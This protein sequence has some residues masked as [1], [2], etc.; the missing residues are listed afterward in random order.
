MALG[1]GVWTTQSKELPGSYLNFV[2]ASRANTAL[3]A[4][5]V[6]AFPIALD[7][8]AEQTVI[9]VTAESFRKDAK[10]IFGYAQSHASLKGLRDLFRNIRK[11]YFFRLNQGGMKA[12]N[13]YACARHPGSRGND[14][15]IVIQNGEDST[16]EL[17][18]YDVLTYLDNEQVDE[19]RG[20]TSPAALASN[21]YVEFKRD[22]VLELT[23]GAP[24]VGGVTGAVKN[25]AYQTCIDRL[26][27]YAFNTLG[28]LS[29]DETVKGLFAA[30]VKRLRDELGVKCQCV[31]FR[32][33]RADYE[34]V[35]SVENGLR[36]AKDDP[37]AVFWMTGASAGCLVNETNMNRAYDGEFEIDTDYTQAQLEDGLRAGKLFFHRVGDETRV[38]DDINTFVSFTDEKGTD[39]SNNQT[40]R[41]LDQIGNDIAVLFNT[42]YLGKVP[43]DNAGRISLW[44]DI[45]KHH[46]ALQTIRAIEDFSSED[47]TVGMGDTKK[48]VLVTDR[49]TPT[50]SMSQLYMTVVVS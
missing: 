4:R 3:S 12:S 41:V 20:I 5:G 42:R 47:V 44:N 43:N 19:Q 34:G 11:G 37:S 38:L 7:W 8:G 16:E 1:G 26:E 25:E 9:E 31:L 35:I 10:K 45:V 36:E 13:A 23:A 30:Y 33:N 17:P 39:F 6:A 49:V 27:P 28:C 48:S 29:V 14:I 24:L 2:S 40:V 15:R 22:A 21:D 18:V 32:Y 46:Q 50:S